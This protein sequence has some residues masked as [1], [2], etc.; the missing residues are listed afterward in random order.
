[1]NIQDMMNKILYILEDSRTGILATTDMEGRPHMRWMTPVVL[2]EKPDIL[3]A[4]T[5]P[6]FQKA[7]QLEQCNKVEWMLQTRAL[8]QIVNIK[9]FINIIDNPSVKAQ[10]MEYAGNRLTVFWNANSLNT[11][12]IALETVVEEAVWYVPMKGIRETVNFIKEASWG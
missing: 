12:F 9:G 2:R 7:L 6:H 10:I 8:D 3:Y 5:S 1:M 11:D 4:V